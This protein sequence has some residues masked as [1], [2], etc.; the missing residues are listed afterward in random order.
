MATAMAHRWQ[1]MRW[2]EL[3]DGK[4]DLDR[5]PPPAVGRGRARR[6]EGDRASTASTTGA[7][8]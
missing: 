4:D 8:R 2:G 6:Q 1:K 3:E 7:T 5:L